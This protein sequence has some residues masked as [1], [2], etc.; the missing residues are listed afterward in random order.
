VERRG[1][2]LG[3]LGHDLAALPVEAGRDYGLVAEGTHTTY[4]PNGEIADHE[5]LDEWKLQYLLPG[6]EG[7]TWYVHRYG[8]R[9]RPSRAQPA[10]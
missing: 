10:Q 7:A 9:A 8:D 5:L 6:T 2:R 1:C 4:G 3:R